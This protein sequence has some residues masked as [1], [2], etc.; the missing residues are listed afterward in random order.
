[1]S[2]FRVTVGIFCTLAAR[3]GAAEPGVDFNRDVRPILAENCFKCHGPDE[4]ERKAKL[5]LDDRD[6]A[7]KR[8]AFVPGTARDSE[9]IA[10][11]TNS[12]LDKRMPPLKTGKKLTAHQI[13]MLR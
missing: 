11:V 2:R 6:V 1:M 7:L 8:G 12:D 13:D 10:R 3:L 5:R 4:K 9:L